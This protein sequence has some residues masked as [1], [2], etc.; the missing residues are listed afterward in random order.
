VWL[1]RIQTWGGGGLV[2]TRWWCESRLGQHIRQRA[3][4]GMQ[5]Q[6]IS[7]ALVEVM[8]KG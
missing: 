5:Q 8:A 7:A 1:C 2:K 3:I 4:D 6:H